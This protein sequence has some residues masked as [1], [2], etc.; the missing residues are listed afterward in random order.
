MNLSFTYEFW[1][2]FSPRPTCNKWKTSLFYYLTFPRDREKY[3]IK[4]LGDWYIVAEEALL[5]V[6]RTLERENFDDKY[7]IKHDILFAALA[8]IMYKGIRY[9]NSAMI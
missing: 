6:T 2:K 3:P 4:L 7:I 5:D 8:I 1:V 9:E